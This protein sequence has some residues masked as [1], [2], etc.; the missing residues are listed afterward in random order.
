[1]HLFL[2]YHGYRITADTD[3]CEP[4]TLAVATGQVDRDHLAAWLEG[5]A[6][7]LQ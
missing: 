6:F 4:I 7:R 1:M 5:Y 2:Q 3:E